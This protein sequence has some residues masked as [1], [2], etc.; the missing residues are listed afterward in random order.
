[1]ERNRSQ[2]KV[3]MT[4]HGASCPGEMIVKNQDLSPV[5]YGQEAPTIDDIVK[6]IERARRKI[7]SL[8]GQ[9]RK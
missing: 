6:K 1:M 7:D 4:L 8:R 3:G 5:T 9:V 2:I